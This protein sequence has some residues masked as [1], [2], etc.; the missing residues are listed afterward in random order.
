[1]DPNPNQHERRASGALSGSSNRP[2]PTRLPDVEVRPFPPIRDAER[3]PPGRM[4][5]DPKKALD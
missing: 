3:P 2:K 1:M 5:A 4:R